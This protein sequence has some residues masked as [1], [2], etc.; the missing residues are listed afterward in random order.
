MDDDRPAPPVPSTAGF[1]RRLGATVIDLV[2]A[3]LVAALFTRPHLPGS[4]LS[5]GVWI[6]AHTFFVGFFGETPG[7]RLLGL[8]CTTPAGRVPGPPRALLRAVL[9]LL[10][11]PV[12]LTDETGRRWHDRLAGTTVGRQPRD[13]RAAQRP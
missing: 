4:S 10:I 2:L 11:V 6:V 9:I 8:H 12:L 7:M 1:G 5:T 13:T 3:G